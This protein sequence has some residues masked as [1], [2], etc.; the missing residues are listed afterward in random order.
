[1]ARFIRSRNQKYN[2]A[3]KVFKKKLWRLK[4]RN[5]TK[6]VVQLTLSG[7]MTKYHK[8]FFFFR[9]IYFGQEGFPVNPHSCLVSTRYNKQQKMLKMMTAHWWH[10]VY[11]HIWQFVS[12]FT[13]GTVS[14][15]PWLKFDLDLAPC[16]LKAS[17]IGNNTAE[18]V[19]MGSSYS[20]KVTVTQLM[21]AS[22]YQRLQLII[23]FKS[24]LVL[25]KDAYLVNHLTDRSET[26]RKQDPHKTSLLPNGF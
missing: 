4:T 20:V 8:L 7:L 11:T 10:P 17:S 9:D 16:A 21:Q 13:L 14:L 19:V 15:C 3:S 25:A 24:I 6:T 2:L 5:K 1:M 22:T 26:F 23:R 12:L 18:V